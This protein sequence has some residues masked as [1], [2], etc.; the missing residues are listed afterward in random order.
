MAKYSIDGREV[1]TINGFKKYD[2]K[3]KGNPYHDELGRFTTAATGKRISLDKKLY[4][5]TPQFGEKKS[6]SKWEAEQRESSRERTKETEER[7]KIQESILKEEKKARKKKAKLYD[8]P[9]TKKCVA[10][11]G[12]TPEQY[13]LVHKRAWNE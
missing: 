5:I 1:P 4:K 11:T 2:N 7:K 9:I 10:E 8:D 13:Q 6:F 3:G 12:L